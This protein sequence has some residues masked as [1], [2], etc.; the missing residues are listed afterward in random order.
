[1]MGRGLKNKLNQETSMPSITTS[2]ASKL[3][4]FGIKNQGNESTSYKDDYVSQNPDSFNIDE[5]QGEGDR[6]GSFILNNP[7]GSI[8][9]LNVLNEDVLRP[10][11][12][13]RIWIF[14]KLT[15]YSSENEGL[16]VQGN[17]HPRS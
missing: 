15:E 11:R 17:L 2:V 6:K 3:N 4:H 14:G 7:L 1:M 9:A 16:A 5:G 13:W 8:T 10:W 12:C